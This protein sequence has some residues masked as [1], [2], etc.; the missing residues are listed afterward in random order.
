[1]PKVHGKAF[2]NLLIVFGLIASLMIW[3]AQD[4]I[5]K[6]NTSEVETP[7]MD[8]HDNTYESSQYQRQSI[9]SKANPAGVIPLSPEVINALLEI[10]PKPPEEL[11]KEESDELMKDMEEIYATMPTEPMDN[12]FAMK[13]PVFKLFDDIKKKIQSLTLSNKEL[14]GVLYTLH[15]LPGL[16][17][18]GQQVMDEYLYKD[19]TSMN[20]LSDKQQSMILEKLPRPDAM[21]SFDAEQWNEGGNDIESQDNQITTD[22]LLS[23]VESEQLPGDLLIHGKSLYSKINFEREHHLPELKERLNRLNIE[24][25]T[26]DLTNFIHNYQTSFLDETMRGTLLEKINVLFGDLDLSQAHLTTESYNLLSITAEFGSIEFLKFLQRQGFQFNKPNNQVFPGFSYASNNDEDDEQEAADNNIQQNL[27]DDLIRRS[28]YS[29][30]ISQ[31]DTI[32]SLNYLLSQDVYP[33]DKSILK[34]IEQVHDN[35]KL[36]KHLNHIKNK[37]KPI[38]SLEH[39]IEEHNID[40]AGYLSLIGVSEEDKALLKKIDNHFSACYKEAQKKHKEWENDNRFLLEEL[41]DN[42]PYDEFDKL[43]VH[44]HKNFNN[45]LRT[46]KQWS[47]RNKKKNI[48]SRDLNIYLLTIDKRLFFINQFIEYDRAIYP[49]MIHEN[50]F[51]YIEEAFEITQDDIDDQINQYGTTYIKQ[52]LAL[53]IQMSMISEQVKWFETIKEDNLINETFYKHLNNVWISFV[54]AD[55]SLPSTRYFKELKKLDIDFSGSNE[56]TGNLLFYA[57]MNNDVSLVRYLLSD[58][59]S[60]EKQQDK[61]NTLDVVLLNFTPAKSELLHI[62]L[63]HN[64]PLDKTHRRLMAQLKAKY[65]DHV[66]DM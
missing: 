55:E 5:E 13:K 10:P 15:T 21:L 7:I 12:C 66:P 34:D 50:N 3:W 22:T 18:L 58:Q 63:Q 28:I 35:E 49:D 30:Q 41:Q 44:Y 1:M 16:E 14:E 9:Q 2:V 4:G 47:F 43:F 60:I 52:E 61:I 25:T 20:E 39:Y 53:I 24:P 36:Q 42:M 29:R 26:A 6:G 32:E 19:R 27:A 11:S 65:P 64:F 48:S 23:Y 17:N 37:F 33:S 51:S 38:Q 54:L 45:A 59:D 57:A 31:E 46:F 56:K 40:I 62:F 8:E